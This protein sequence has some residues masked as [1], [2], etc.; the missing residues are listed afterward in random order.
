M[1]DILLIEDE[2]KLG[3]ILSTSLS[4]YNFRVRYCKD[5]LAGFQSF[6]TTKPDIIVLDV[7]MPMLDGFSVAKKIRETDHITP[8]IF[9]T[10]RTGQED[11]LKGF[12][13]GGNDYLKK[14]FHID[15]LI[16]RIKSLAKLSNTY[17]PSHDISIG[18]Y[19]LNPSKQLLI[20]NEQQ[21]AL[22]YRECEILKRLYQR[23]NTVVS[24][25]EIQTEFWQDD[26]LTSGRSL[27]VFISRLRKYLKDDTSLKIVNVR[28]I[29]YQF[30]VD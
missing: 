20:L 27:D 7:M 15:E 19:I 2:E 1:I 18:K 22:S 14:P 6:Q 4:K 16:A 13:F 24:R 5:G 23:K 11:V 10:A 17:H 8:I 28:N 25:K 12:E 30:K 3:F 21:T 29:G 9:L 26:P